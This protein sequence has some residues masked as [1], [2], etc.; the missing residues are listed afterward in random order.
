MPP[1]FKFKLLTEFWSVKLCAK[2][3]S[4]R[5]VVAV[6]LLDV[7]VKVTTYC[8]ILAELLAA[9]ITVV[10]PVVGLG[11]KD[12]VTPAGKPDAVKVMPSVKP[13]CA[14]THMYEVPELP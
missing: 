1:S 5:V 9:S 3:P 7:P 8:P 12:A 11:E 14:F 13:Y 10:L 4:V 2:I 6:W